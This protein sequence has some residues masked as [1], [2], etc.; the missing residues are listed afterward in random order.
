MRA[1][2]TE[3]H[4][5]DSILQGSLRQTAE[6]EGIPGMNVRETYNF[7]GSDFSEFP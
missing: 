6:L 1:R 2:K 3:T 7:P 5:G 4:P